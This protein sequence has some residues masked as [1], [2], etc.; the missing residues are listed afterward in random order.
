MLR[1]TVLVCSRELG[2]PGGTWRALNGAVAEAGRGQRKVL[3]QVS[4]GQQQAQSLM[5]WLGAGHE[6]AQPRSTGGHQGRGITAGTSAKHF[7]SAQ[8]SL[9]RQTEAPGAC[10]QGGL[11]R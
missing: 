2:I 3:P 6:A 9:L 4:E 1:V 11:L 7:T 8:T 5:A 10:W